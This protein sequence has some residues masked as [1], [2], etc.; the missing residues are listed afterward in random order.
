MAGADTSNIELDES[1]MWENYADRATKVPSQVLY[2][3]VTC[4]SANNTGFTF[5]FRSP[6][7]NALLDND[8]VI[9]YNVTITKTG[10][11]TTLRHIGGGIVG[12]TPAS[13]KELTCAFRQCFPV[14]RAIQNR[15]W[16]R[17]AHRK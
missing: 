3:Q 13:I 11:G 4:D 14:A 1:L 7:D 8:V 6:A 12:L 10:Y 16:R 17:V 5:N 2:E 15:G 9:E